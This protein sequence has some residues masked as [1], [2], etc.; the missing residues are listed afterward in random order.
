MT[1]RSVAPLGIPRANSQISPVEIH[2]VAEER[3][4]HRGLRYTQGRKQIVDLLIDTDH[5]ISIGEIAA[6]L[7]G[8]PRSSAYRHLVDLQD[9]SVVH[10]VEAG[11]EFNRYELTEDLTGHHHHLC[12]TNCG[13]IIDVVAT[14]D[15]ERSVNRYLDELPKSFGFEAH[16]HRMDVFGLC[17]NCQ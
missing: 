6:A 1:S 13:T 17:S 11:D 12:C 9:A 8:L 4:Q 2:I 14:S 15:L 16:R 10:K 7:P 5:P 3:L